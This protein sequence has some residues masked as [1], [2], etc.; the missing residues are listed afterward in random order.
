[1]ASIMIVDAEHLSEM[2]EA[3]Q[4]YVKDYF[5]E[6]PI[7]GKRTYVAARFLHLCEWRHNAKG[8]APSHCVDLSH[9]TKGLKIGQSL[10]D[11]IDKAIRAGRYIWELP[12]GFD[13]DNVVNVD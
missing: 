9:Y 4:Q 11:W 12:G 6:K 5:V 1:V 2:P 7:L 3:F 8:H 10:N 13:S